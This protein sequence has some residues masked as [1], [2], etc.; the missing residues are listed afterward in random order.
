MAAK[1]MHGPQ[2]SPT[3]NEIEK[4]YNDSK[5]ESLKFSFLTFSEATA[6]CKAQYIPPSTFGLT[7]LS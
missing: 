4:I 3:A 1:Q 5:S 2:K 7:A 6:E